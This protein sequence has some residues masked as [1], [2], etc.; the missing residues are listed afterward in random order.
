MKKI[1]AILLAGMMIMLCACNKDNGDPTAEITTAPAMRTSDMLDITA[2]GLN[3]IDCLNRYYSVITAVKNKVQI[4]E[5]EHNKI[6]ENANGDRYFLDENYILTY[7]DPFLMNSL[8]L[9]EGFKDYTNPAD[10]NAYY[11]I[12][13]NGADI[14]YEIKN[15]ATRALYFSSEDSVKEFKAEYNQ[16]NDSFRYT[17]YTDSDGN[18]VLD[19]SLEFVKLTRNIYLIQSKN[20]RCYVEFDDTGKIVYFC[21]TVLK[22]GT[23]TEADT[24]YDGN[25]ITDGRSWAMAYE[26]DTYLSIHTYEN[27]VMTHEEC[28]SGPWKS[29]SIN[30][31][32]YASAFLF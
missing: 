15:T 11:T 29:V 26:K 4:L 9:T 32:D 17:A 18:R 19:E 14:R 23:Y 7:F 28:S 25:V 22:G 21:C 12:Y 30:E 10:V 5:N 1:L 27:G 31:S 24:I 16:S 3:Y 13:S 8:F 2:R 6:I 20:A